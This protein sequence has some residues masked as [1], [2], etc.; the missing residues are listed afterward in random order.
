MMNAC[1]TLQMDAG[2]QGRD[3]MDLGPI[4]HPAWLRRRSIDIHQVA[5]LEKIQGGEVAR[6]R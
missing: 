1:L 6:K 2:E 5:R 3:K 4:F